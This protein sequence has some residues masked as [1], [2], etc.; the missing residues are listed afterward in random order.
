[1]FDCFEYDLGL[2]CRDENC[3]HAR[4]RE[5]IH[6]AHHVRKRSDPVFGPD[7]WR[8]QCSSA[9]RESV[10]SAVSVAEPRIFTTILQLV[11]NDYGSVLGRSVHR[12]LKF[13]REC[14]EIL[15]LDFPGRRYAYLRK[16][17]RLVN[18]P[19]LVYEQIMALHA[20]AWTP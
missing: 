11:E 18:D 12:H 1:M 7:P 19:G 8:Q 13:W 3:P 9:L 14:G 5:G 10:L 17:S 6:L 15:R 2:I 20:E 4:D 16:G